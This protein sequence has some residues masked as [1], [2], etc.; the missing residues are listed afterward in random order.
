MKA[1][2]TRQRTGKNNLL[3]V[4]IWFNEDLEQVKKND[5]E[6]DTSLIKCPAG[7]DINAITINEIALSIVAEIIREKNL[8]DKQ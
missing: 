8:S 7:V 3:F 1:Q 5:P 4:F 6:L 2:E